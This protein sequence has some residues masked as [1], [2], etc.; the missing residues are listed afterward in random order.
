[1][2]Y[3]PL[4]QTSTPTKNRILCFLD[5]TMNLFQRLC[6]DPAKSD[7]ISRAVTRADFI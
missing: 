2:I 6:A 7:L 3:T 1:M 4:N 5:V